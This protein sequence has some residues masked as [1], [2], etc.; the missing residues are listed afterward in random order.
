MQKRSKT[1]IL[2]L[3]AVNMTLSLAASAQYTGPGGSIVLNPVDGGNGGWDNG[4]GSYAAEGEAC[5]NEMLGGTQ[6]CMAGLT[7][8]ETYVNG[9]PLSPG[10]CMVACAHQGGTGAECQPG[11][12]CVDLNGYSVCQYGND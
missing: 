4:A 1:F 2:F 6:P 7:C 9:E 10:T 8:T 11:Q 12:F 3:C 5:S